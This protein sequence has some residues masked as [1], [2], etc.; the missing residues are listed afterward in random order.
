MLSSVLDLSATVTPYAVS[1]AAG[2]EPTPFLFKKKLEVTLDFTTDL[3]RGPDSNQRPLGYEPNELPLLLPRNIC[4]VPQGFEPRFSGSKPDVLPLHHR[5]ICDLQYVKE[6]CLLLDNFAIILSFSNFFNFLSKIFWHGWRDSNSH[7]RFWRPVCYH[8]TTPMC[9]LV[10]G[11]GLEPGTSA[12]ETDEI[13]F[14]THPAICIF[15]SDPDRI[16]TCD[17]HI[18]SMVL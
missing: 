15:F 14:S 7:Q 16:R 1:D 8:C 18:K 10:A 11:P 3:L 4:V 13:A 5:T 12:Y 17:S 2:F 9:F 6:L